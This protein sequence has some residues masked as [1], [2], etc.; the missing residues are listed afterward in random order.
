MKSIF[1]IALALAFSACSVSA[2]AQTPSTSKAAPK[3][4]Q[5]VVSLIRTKFYDGIKVHRV[6]AGFV[7]QMGDPKTKTGGVDAPGVGSGGSGQNVPFEQNSLTNVAG[8]V[9]MALSEISPHDSTSA[10]LGW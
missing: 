2:Y 7:V 3:T 8:T 9:A 6:E 5:H 1:I 10:S 4:V